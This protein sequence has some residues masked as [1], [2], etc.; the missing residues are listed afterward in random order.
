MTTLPKYCP[1]IGKR[2]N[3]PLRSQSAMTS[4]SS[5]LIQVNN[6]VLRKSDKNYKEF[7]N[8]TSSDFFFADCE[9]EDCTCLME[10]FSKCDTESQS[11]SEDILTF[12][13]SK[14]MTSLT[15]NSS[16]IS[17]SS[18]HKVDE[19]VF[20]VDGYEVTCTRFGSVTNVRYSENSLVVFTD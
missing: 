16:P 17:V 1:P 4:T 7:F 19:E 13:D 11:D 12:S 3:Q 6:Q 15:Q 18:V 14:E 10:I 20:D 2:Y 9:H 5:E 8:K